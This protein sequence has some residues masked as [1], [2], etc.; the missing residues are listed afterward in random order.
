LAC[1]LVV[2]LGLVWTSAGVAGHGFLAN[3]PDPVAEVSLG[4]PV[5]EFPIPIRSTGNEDDSLDVVLTTNLPQGWFAQFC[6]VST[7]T[8]YFDAAR[9]ALPAGAVDTIRVDIFPSATEAGHGW[10][11]LDVASASEPYLDHSCVF[12]LYSGETIPDLG[13]TAEC[14]EELAL[15]VEGPYAQAEFMIPISRTGSDPDSVHVVLD[16]SGLPDGWFAQ[17]CRVSTGTCYFDEAYFSFPPGAPDSIRVDIVTGQDP[18]WGEVT[19]WAH[20][21]SVPSWGAECALRVYDRETSGAPE[22]PTLRPAS[23]RVFPNPTSGTTRMELRIPGGGSARLEILSPDGRRILQRSL[24]V[25]DSG[26]LRLAW[27]GRAADGRRLPAGVY[28]VRLRGEN[29]HM[30]RKVLLIR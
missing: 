16:S 2:T 18:G 22:P 28:L 19:L 9:I 10:V 20:S 21:V 1:A 8:C 17:F 15:W 26:I 29:L 7:G 27:D 30:S 25:P 24:R 12:T 14:P 4:T 23:L 5:A 13:F 11:R 3:C 6:Q